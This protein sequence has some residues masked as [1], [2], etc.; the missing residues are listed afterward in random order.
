MSTALH[1]KTALVTGAGRGIGRAIAVGLARGGAAIGLV[2]RSRDELAETAR[3][4]QAA[5][6]N[7]F[8]IVADLADPAAPAGIAQRA[9][10][11]LGTVEVLVNNAGVVAPVKATASLDPAEWATALAVNVTAVASLTIALL[12]AML[13]RG[14]GRIANV[15]SGAAVDPAGMIRANAYVTGKAA[16][17]AHTLNLAAELAGTGVTVN[18]YRPGTVDTAMQAWIRGQDPAQVG[19]GLHERFNEFH[20]TGSLITPEASAASLLA[21]LPG[22]ATA[23]VWSVSDPL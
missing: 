1:G 7:P 13:D 4:V 11:E 21:R 20:S 2:A 19:A 8:V 17:E 12:P 3:L 18:V 5:G 10:D 16:L 15:S 14:W 23:Q 22:E 6:G 9:R